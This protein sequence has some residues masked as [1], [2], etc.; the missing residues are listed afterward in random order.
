MRLKGAKT[1]AAKPVWESI[2]TG[3]AMLFALAGPGLSEG[4]GRGR[5]WGLYSSS[6]CRLWIPSRM[7][8][9]QNHPI[10]PLITRSISVTQHTITV[11]VLLRNNKKHPKFPVTTSM[12]L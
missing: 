12:I 7:N 4:V 10:C 1:T 9:R 11:P 8:Y 2:Q 6:R 5:G 3:M